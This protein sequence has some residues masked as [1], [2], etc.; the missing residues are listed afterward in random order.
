MIQTILVFIMSAVLSVTIFYIL[1]IVW[2]GD[3][4]TQMVRSFFAMG[5]VTAFWIIFNGVMAISDAKSLPIMLSLG[6]VCVCALPFALLWFSLNYIRSPLIGSKLIFG[7]IVGIP[8]LDIFFLITSPVHRLYF[9]DYNF[10]FPGKG[11]IF[12]IHTAICIVATLLSF[13]CIMM[14]TAKAQRDKI[15]TFGAGIGILVSAV[16]HIRFAFDSEVIYDLSPIGFFVTFLL[17]GFSAHKVRILRLRR[18]TL[19]QIFSYLDDICFIF[20]EERV[21]IE[22]NPAA[23]K[24]FPQLPIE[25]WTTQI[26]DLLG[27]MQADMKGRI[28]KDILEFILEK[29]GNCEGEINLVSSNGQVKTYTLSWHTIAHKN[30]K[31]GYMLLLADI[32]IYRNMIGEISEKNDILIE[33]NNKAMAAAEAKSTFLANMSHEI[34]TPL[35]AIIGMSHIAKDSLEDR[36]KISVSI[37]HITRA[38]KH[39]LELLN[40]ILDMSKIE[41]GKF[42]LAEDPFSLAYVLEEVTSMFSQRCD[43]NNLTLAVDI[44]EMPELVIGDAL[45][46]KQVIIN[47]LG[48]AVKFSSSNGTIRLIAKKELEQGHLLLNIRISDTGIGMTGEQVSRLFNA[49]EQADSS[50]AARF[51]GTGMGL[52]LSQHLIGLMGGVIEAESSIG[53]GSVF[54]FTIELPVQEDTRKS[55]AGQLNNYPPDLSGKRI[56]I[57]DDIDINRFILAEF[58][59]NTNAYIEEAVDGAQALEMFKKSPKGYYDLIF[60]DVQMPNMNGY[61]ATKKIRSSPH[62]DAK[63]LLI[64]AMTANAYKEDVD[65]ALESGMSAHLSKPIDIDKVYALIAQIFAFVQ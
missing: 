64:V 26:G 59:S 17:F 5:V 45:R 8:L 36:E 33:L 53:Q 18:K 55:E 61:D 11:I 9:T 42:T 24:A 28:P 4:R 30:Y 38:S 23:E 3:K 63:A 34:R 32:S 52:A 21:L 15:I 43:E 22:C 41:S 54:S 10:P 7:L 65:K 35:N 12:W 56:L 19:D 37:E 29:E 62:E 14:Q 27:Y 20:D 25:K 40:N 6:M 39:L 51:G 50:I 44:D 16:I 57:V 13:I 48:N 60:M 1:G 49:F 2:F 58:L 31:R 47:L 46:F